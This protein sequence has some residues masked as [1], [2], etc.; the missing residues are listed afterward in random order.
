MKW[1]GYIGFVS[2][3]ETDPGIYKDVGIEK[4]YKGYITRFNRQIKPD[5]VVNDSP[6]LDIQIRVYINPYLN[7]NIY[8][9]KYITYMNKKW[10]ITNV[11]VQYPQIIFSLGGLYFNEDAT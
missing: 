11:E 10:K 5:S 3:Q 7:D 1:C 9:I 4:R 6:L 8:N 2:T